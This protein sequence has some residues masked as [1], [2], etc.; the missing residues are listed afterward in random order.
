[1]ELTPRARRTLVAL[2]VTYAAVNA[3]IGVR[4]GGDF[5]FHLRLADRLLRG[6]PMYTDFPGEIGMPWPP[7]AIFSLMPFAL[8]ARLSLPLVKALWAVGNV[9]LFGWCLVQAFR[10]AGRWTPVVL[11]VAA[12]AQPLQSNFQYLNI[13]IVL[14]A[15]IVLAIDQV[16]RGRELQ[17]ALCVAVAT[18]LKG[19]PGAVFLYFLVRGR[20]RPLIAGVAAV[21]GLSALVLL[22]AGLA[23]AAIIP[24]YVHLAFTAKSTQGLA[25]QA[26]GGLVTRLGGDFAVIVT[27]DLLAVAAVSAVLW[28]GRGLGEPMYDFGTAAL[29]A[30]LLSPLDRLHYYVLA[31][32]AW[33]DTFSHAAPPPGGSK[34]GGPRGRGRAVWVS[35]LA[36][37][38]L[39]TSG[40][41]SFIRH[42]PEPFWFIRQNT[43]TLGAFIFLLLLVL[44]RAPLL[45][46]QP[47]VAQPS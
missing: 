23:G 7:F 33:S 31:F 26:I 5:V 16:E 27:L 41:L 1:M 43:Y 25:G 39:L 47:A 6:Q 17:A 19:Y 28:R 21:V 24:D 22:P 34:G 8:V 29:L 13:N 3:F 42:L 10:H 14:L 46:P 38:A 36:A 45:V 12:V 32:P 35:A 18:A 40:M 44:R 4:Q 15:L 20:W 30:V 37:T 2:G 9:A 11:A